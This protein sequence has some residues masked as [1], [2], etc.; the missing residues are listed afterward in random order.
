MHPKRPPVP[1][2]VIL[3][4]VLLV[5]GYYGLQALFDETNGGLQASVTI[6]AV[7]VSVSPEMAGKVTEVLADEG[8]AV[9]VD[10]PL[11]SLDG[12]LLAAQRQ[13][14]ASQLDSAMA[15]VQAAQSALNTASYQYQ[16]T[17]ASS[18][19]QDKGTRLQDW[20]TRD[21][22]QFEQPEWYFTR[23]EQ[24][25]AAQARV[26]LAYQ[27]LGNAQSNM[28]NVSQSLE[29]AE[30][31]EAEKRLLDAR[32][33]Y[34]IAKDVDNR[35]E[36]SVTSDVPV[37]RYNATHCGTNEGYFVNN[38]RLTNQIYRC[39]GDEYLSD[40]SQVMYDN[41]QNEL[42]SA[43]DAYDDLLTTDAADAVLLAR[44]QVSV[45]QERYY[46][47]LDYLRA[48]QTGDQSTSVAAAEAAM[49]QAQAAADQAQK[50]VEQAQANLKLIDTQIAK[51]SVYAPATGTILTRNIEPGEFIQPGATVFT[52]ANLD[53]LT[54]TV[55]VPEDRYGEIS[56]GQQAEVKVDS[57]PGQNF[58]ASVVYISSSAEFTPRNVQTVEG[59]SAT[60]Y[61]IKL[62]VQ[63]PEGKLKPGMPAD[64]TF[65]R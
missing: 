57:F 6:E 3:L 62:K 54:I 38:A 24:I 37:G 10:D 9:N 52:L 27:D 55:Y 49:E 42:D 40:V 19:E 7:D 31:L 41:A 5:G 58:S 32:L 28:V 25:S 39:T 33:E 26:D 45:A 18:R 8:D 21:P 50:A 35:A 1:V 46:T 4:L 2:I 29:V 51:L 44:A 22:N 30:F 23:T 61:A 60:V 59:R 14:A 13:V 43:Q 63:D 56:L 64:V 15:G 20:F 36:N 12:S 53:N 11:L 48:L 16:I 17:L 47:A 65:S 34:L